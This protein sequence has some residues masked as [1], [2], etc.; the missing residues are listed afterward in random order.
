MELAGAGAVSGIVQA[1][2]FFKTCALNLPQG[3]VKEE[4]EE[5]AVEEVCTTRSNKSLRESVTLNLL[6]C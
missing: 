4:E 1:L 5:E 3:T 6:L 2:S